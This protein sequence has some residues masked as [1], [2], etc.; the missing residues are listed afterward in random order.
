MLIVIMLCVFMLIVVM[1]SVVMLSVVALY[2]N[3]MLPLKVIVMS[4]TELF[5]RGKGN[6]Y[7]YI[8]DKQCCLGLCLNPIQ[9]E[10]TF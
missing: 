9:S 7:R 8:P 5:E 10:R 1:V 4:N 2:V 3:V 6:I